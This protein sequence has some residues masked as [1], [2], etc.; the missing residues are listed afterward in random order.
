MY[1][2][3]LKDDLAYML[4]GYTISSGN[5]TSD[6]LYLGGSQGGI[7]IQAVANVA[8]QFDSLT[9]SV[10]HSDSPDSGFST[11]ATLYDESGSDV[12]ES[13]GAVLERYTLPQDCKPYVRISVTVT[14]GDS[15]EL[16]IYPHPVGR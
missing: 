2:H 7:E 3:T 1:N 16:T 15:G 10:E 8:L 6:S 13:E 11:L 5:K 4:E 14:S 12:T 9:I